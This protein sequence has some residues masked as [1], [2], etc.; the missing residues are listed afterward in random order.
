MKRRSFL[1]GAGVTLGALALGPTFGS[2]IAAAAE[3]QNRNFIFCYFEGGWDHLLGLDPRD[4]AEF[5]DADAPATGI[6]PGFARLPANIPHSLIDAGPFTLGPCAHELAEVAD[7]LCLVRGIN[8]ATLT[9]EVGRRYFITG[10]PPSGLRARGSSVAA[11]ATSQLG[12]DRPV[13]Y[14]ACR[15]ETYA[16]NL[17]SFASAMQIA[18]VEHVRYILQ[19]N[20]GIPTYTRPSVLD[21][22]QAYHHR[23]VNCEQSGVGGSRQAELYRENRARATDLVASGLQADFEFDSPAHANLRAHYG[24]APGQ[25]DTAYGRAALAAQCVRTGLS[26]VVSVM[27][28]EKLDTHGQEWANDHSQ[29]LKAGFDAFSRLIQDLR[30]S[31]DPNSTGSLL[32]STTVIAFSEFG[33][34]ARLNER[35]GRDHNLTNAAILAGAGIAGG[36]VVGST[37]DNGLGPNLIDLSTGQSSEAGVSLKPEHVMSSVLASAGLDAS[38]LRSEPVPALLA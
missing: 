11:L 28:A 35:N 32:D 14:L 29:N 21:A 34:T 13:P 2:R 10:R 37:S 1:R 6:E 15:V 7:E 24:F 9:H 31:P 8:M 5:K 16:E 38:E 27:L 25:V 19:A 36:Q 30:D 26:R 4:P 33:R 3:A 23:Q 22:V 17:P 18:S 20:L 12:G